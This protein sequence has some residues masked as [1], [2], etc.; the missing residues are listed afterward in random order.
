MLRYLTLTIIVLA[1]LTGCSLHAHRID[2][3]DL[4]GEHLW[5]GRIDVYGDVVLT[6]GSLLRI[7]PGSELVFHPPG[8]GQDRW[9]SHPNFIGSE[10]IV[11]GIFFAEGTAASPIVFR[12]ADPAAE[13]GS[14]GG[15]NISGSPESHI[16]HV[17]F[18]QADSALHI[19]ESTAYVEHSVFSDNY[20]GVRFHS[21][22]IL[23]EQNRFENNDTGVRFHFGSPVICRNQFIGNRRGLF[24]TSHP[25]D[26]LIENNSFLNS[27]DYHIVLGEEVPEAIPVLHNWWGTTDTAAILE[28]LY[29]GRRESHLG[30]VSIEPLRTSPDPLAGTP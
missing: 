18:S 11:R 12:S 8:P 24:I 23:I 16:S 6:E 15:V 14:W 17:R 22:T 20:V 1:F 13:A 4:S 19:Q 3:G 2:S 10:L 7:A 25:Q 30:L 5:Q 28:K 9:Q 29:D 27:R 21:S 26:F